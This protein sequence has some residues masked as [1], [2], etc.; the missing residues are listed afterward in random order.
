NWNGTWWDWLAFILPR[1]EQTAIY[2][3]INFSLFN[4]NQNSANVARDPNLTVWVSVVNSYLCPSD[5]VGSGVMSNMAWVTGANGHGWLSQQY[6]GAVTCYVGNWGDMKTGNTTFDFYSG[7]SAPG[8]GPN[9]GCN[10]TFRGIFS[11]CS[12]GKGIA[13]R[14]ITDGTSNT[15]LAGE[16]SPN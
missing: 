1:M 8:V 12:N 14:D 9:W 16:C 10:G 15:F 6:T 7:E 3:S 2:N 5:Q 11:D 4:I 13:I